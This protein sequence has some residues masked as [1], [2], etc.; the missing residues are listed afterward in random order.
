MTLPL[1]PPSALRTPSSQGPGDVRA[2]FAAL[3]Y[4]LAD[5]DPRVREAIERLDPEG[6]ALVYAGSFT[7]ARHLCGRRVIGARTRA[8]LA[9]EGKLEQ[10]RLLGSG[11]TV[12]HL[13]DELPPPPGRVVLQGVPREGVAMGSSHTYLVSGSAERRKR[14]RVRQELLRDCTLALITPFHAG[15]PCT[16]YGFVTA[17]AVH[18]T[19]PVEALVH[20]D[21]Q[22]GR[23]RA[24]GILRPLALPP[25]SLAAARSVVHAIARRLHGDTGYVGGF[26]TDGTLVAER[27]VVHEI[28]PRVCAGF[29]LLDQLSPGSAPLAAADLLLRELPPSRAALLDEPLAAI[30]CGLAHD[31]TPRYRFWESPDH[32]IAPPQEEYPFPVWRIRVRDAARTKEEPCN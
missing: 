25:D 6:D 22:S 8:Q 13:A 28:N 30:T 15:V 2:R 19:G 9:A 14:E 23:L 32:A 17:S 27:Y 16:F 3:E 20:W 24:P 31:P 29:A 21:Q 26:G 10:E 11:A 18:D 4:Q 12:V 1:L 7:T 5:P